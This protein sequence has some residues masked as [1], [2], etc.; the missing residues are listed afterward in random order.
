MPIY[1]VLLMLTLVMI[2][3]MNIMFSFSVVEK[4]FID[5]SQI[6]GNTVVKYVANYTLAYFTPINILCISFFTIFTVSWSEFVYTYAYCIWFF[7]LKKDTITLDKTRVIKDS[8]KYH[9]GFIAYLAINKLIFS[10]V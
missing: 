2:F 8:L 5:A 6:D 4:T 3:I 9:L 10:P 7:S 1:G